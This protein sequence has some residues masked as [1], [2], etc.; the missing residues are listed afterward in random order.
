VILYDPGIYNCNTKGVTDAFKPKLPL[1]QTWTE[2]SQRLISLLVIMV[3]SL[4]LEGFQGVE[5]WGK[6]R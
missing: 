5:S 4:S 1:G 6:I 3:I 2:F